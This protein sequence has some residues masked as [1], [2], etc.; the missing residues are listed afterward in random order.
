MNMRD[1]RTNTLRIIILG[2]MMVLFGGAGSAFADPYFLAIE[3]DSSYPGEIITLDMNLENPAAVSGY[4]LAISYDVSVLT[5]ASI[6]ISGTRS[7][8]FEYFTYR[9]DYRGILG[10]IGIFGLADQN[11]DGTPDNISPG[12]GPIVSLSFYVTNDLNYSGYSVPISFVFRDGLL[13]NDNTLTNPDSVRIDRDSISYTNGFIKIRK[14]PENLIGDINLNGVT[15]EIGDA[16]ILTNYLSFPELAPLSPRQLLNSDVNRD[17]YGATIADLVFMVNKIVNITAFGKKLS[18]MTSPVV[19]VIVRKDAGRMKLAYD[20]EDDLGGL[21]LVLKS[22]EN[23]SSVPDLFSGMEENG[24]MVKSSVNDNLVNVLIYSDDGTR[25]PS[26]YSSFLEIDNKAKFNIDEIQISSADGYLLRPEITGD[27]DNVRPN[28]FALNQNYPNPFNPS[29]ELAFSLPRTS[30]ITLT[31]Y[32][33]L[34]QEVKRL[35]EGTF[36]AGDH[37]VVWDGRDNA[38]RVVSSGVYFYRLTAENFM[39]EKKMLLL[40]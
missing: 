22:Y 1:F 15:Y 10:D 27:K 33:V 6:V 28:D 16:I 4:S 9:L 21:L 3:S 40:K 18:P 38:G 37:S 8:A 12:T 39:T 17:G 36:T 5:P 20:S 7:E 11:G 2:L 31:I 35:V 29:T 19:D 26:G 13:G 23:I 32:N 25:M 24:M 30:D 34:G 14:S